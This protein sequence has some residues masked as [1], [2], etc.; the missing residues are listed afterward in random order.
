LHRKPRRIRVAEPGLGIVVV[1]AA[2][3]AAATLVW[4]TLALGFGFR[5]GPH[6]VM[7]AAG[8]GL[9]ATGLYMFQRGLRRRAR[10]RAIDQLLPHDRERRHY[11]DQADAAAKRNRR[12]INE[13]AWALA[14]TEWADDGADAPLGRSEMRAATRALL[15]SL[16]EELRREAVVRGGRVTRPA[17]RRARLRAAGRVKTTRRRRRHA[18]PLSAQTVS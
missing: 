9:C 3:G 18:R 15:V 13:R 10:L 2:V 14:E 17:C 7:L 11:R 5:P 4:A 12:L 16:E 1:V 8:V 6:P